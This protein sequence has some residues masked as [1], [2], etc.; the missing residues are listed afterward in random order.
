MNKKI[1]LIVIFILLSASVF[2]ADQGTA[3]SKGSL[4]AGVALGYPT[5]FTGGWRATDKFEINALLGTNYLGFTIGV[6]PLFTIVDLDIADQPFPLSVG[7][8]V[9]ISL[10]ALGY[11]AMI[12]ILGVV[13]LEYNFIDLP[14]NLFIEG[15]LGIRIWTYE[16]FFGYQPDALVR[17]GGS[18]VVGARYIF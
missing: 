3:G 12:D 7:P 5:G 1:I 10:G 9:N 8:Q 4:K 11:G 2:A 15:G 13:R 16:S 17:F 14:L 18:G 6:T